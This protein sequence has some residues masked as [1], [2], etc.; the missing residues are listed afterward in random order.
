MGAYCSGLTLPPSGVSEAFDNFLPHEVI[1]EKIQRHRPREEVNVIASLLDCYSHEHRSLPSSDS[2]AHAAHLWELSSPLDLA[3][4]VFTHPQPEARL[5]A[6]EGLCVRLQNA[7]H[8]KE[9]GNDTG[10]LQELETLLFCA[11]LK[12][13]EDRARYTCESE[14]SGRC[15]S[16]SQV[17]KKLGWGL[18]SAANRSLLEDLLL[19]TQ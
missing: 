4:L 13:Q 14:S 17:T 3:H 16:V 9:D 6:Y 18:L 10:L 11:S 8:W 12:S 2:V 1:L 15:F 7:R 19:R 5:Y